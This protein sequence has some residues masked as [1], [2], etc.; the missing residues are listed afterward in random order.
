M[1]TITL[2]RHGQANNKAT[3]EA[4][5]DRLTD[6]GHQQARWLGEWMAAHEQSYDHILS[7]TLRRHRETAAGMGVAAE[8]DPRLN[9]IEYYT[10]T[11][12]AAETLKM[13]HPGPEDFADHM[14]R[15]LAAWKAAEIAGNET[16]QNWH[17]RVE[18]LLA[19]AATPGRRVLCVTSGGIIG[20]VLGQILDLDLLKMSRVMLPIYN[21]S[22]HHL[23][24]RPNGET[25]L[26]GFNHTPHLD[27]PDRTSSR[28]HY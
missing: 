10:L 24:V 19:E 7:G 15:V 4:D 14:P 16:Y 26:A 22:L 18:S 17:D 20:M 6:L 25:I 1:G 2:V 5:Y 23:H 21:S 28:T 9:E 27:A 3:T 12:A 11:N 8:E 13:P